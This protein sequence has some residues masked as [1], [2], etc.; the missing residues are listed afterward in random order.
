VKLRTEERRLIAAVIEKRRPELCHIIAEL[1]S[2]PLSIEEREALRE[3][4]VDEMIEIG[5][6]RN[7][8]PTG[9]GRL[10]DELIGRLGAV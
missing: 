3:A 4:L 2:R 1:G 6:D 9:H 5:L 10:L 7:D 8:E